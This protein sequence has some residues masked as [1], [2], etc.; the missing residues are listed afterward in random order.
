M[1]DPVIA[2]FVGLSLLAIAAGLLVLND[3]SRELG[4]L[5]GCLPIA[6]GVLVIVVCVALLA[7]EHLRI[8]LV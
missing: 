3:R 7:F 4:A 2:V 8:M 1:I 5:V 6:G